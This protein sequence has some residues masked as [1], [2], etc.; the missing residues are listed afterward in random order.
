MLD[1]SGKLPEVQ[2]QLGLEREKV[3]ELIQEKEALQQQLSTS[4]LRNLKE[5]VKRGKDKVVEF[6]T[7][8][9]DS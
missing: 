8:I 7:L 6:V 1:C 5:E 4:K 2:R 3:V 9:I